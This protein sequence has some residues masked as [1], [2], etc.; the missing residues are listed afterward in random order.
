MECIYPETGWT[1][2]TLKWFWNPKNLEPLEPSRTPRTSRT[3]EPAR[4]VPPES[5]IVVPNLV[6]TRGG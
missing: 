4:L 5:P 1:A 2:R 6:A 3:L